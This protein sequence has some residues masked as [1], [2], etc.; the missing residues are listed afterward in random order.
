MSASDDF[1]VHVTDRT[2]G[3]RWQAQSEADRRYKIEQELRKHNPAVKEAWERY[4]VV[5]KLAI[6]I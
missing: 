2:D 5:L 6:D 4:Q 3:K 1:Q